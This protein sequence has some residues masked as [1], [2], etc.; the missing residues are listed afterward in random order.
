MKKN[1][2]PLVGIAFGVALAATALFYFLLASRLPESKTQAN[3]GS[4]VAVAARAIAAG[5]SITADDVKTVQVASR[6]AD[7]LA[8]AGD[9]IGKVAVA[10]IAASEPLSPR[11]VV[12]ADGGGIGV[13][14]GMRAISIQVADSTG[15]LAGIEPGHRVDVQ[16]VQ[17]RDAHDIE[18]RTVAEDV[19]VMKLG[20]PD[21]AGKSSL[22]VVTLLV[23]P[24]DASLI[25][26]ADTST[27]VRLALRNPLD[28]GKLGA[29]SLHV[30]TMMKAHRPTP[31]AAVKP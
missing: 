8:S 11:K 22:P 31:P 7:A 20:P 14:V 28:H 18:L 10:A 29:P 30:S 19:E 26:L 12:A 17:V 5:T 6:P 4:T 15:V 25:A 23:T 16:A 24:T 27:R 2:A 1:L 13:P 3:T 9:A 21:P